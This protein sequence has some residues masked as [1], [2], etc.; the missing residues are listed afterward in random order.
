MS[1][2][3]PHHV[4]SVDK[5]K[6][7][8]AEALLRSQVFSSGSLK[9]IGKVKAAQPTKAGVVFLLEVAP[10]I[11]Q[12]G[13]DNL[14]GGISIEIPLFN[15]LEEGQMRVSP[16]QDGYFEVTLSDGTLTEAWFE[17]KT[18][19]WSRNG[20]IVGCLD[21]INHPTHPFPGVVVGIRRLADQDLTAPKPP[22]ELSPDE[23]QKIGG[24]EGTDGPSG[25][26]K[27][28]SD[29]TETVEDDG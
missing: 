17:Y 5:I 4:E 12:T 10:F 1:N 19:M 23:T 21:Q 27:I 8:I 14:P 18:R 15:L 9:K 28:P 22:R 6:K 2:K 11:A 25:S 26:G 29:S 7:H 13:T 24:I 20:E 16:S 3:P